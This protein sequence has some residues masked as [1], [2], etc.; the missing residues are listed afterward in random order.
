M[1]PSYVLF[2]IL[3]NFLLF[4]SFPLCILTDRTNCYPLSSSKSRQVF[5]AKQMGHFI[6]LLLF[7]YICSETL[8]LLIT[9]MILVF[10]AILPSQS[11]N[12]LFILLPFIWTFLLFCLDFSTQPLNWNVSLSHYIWEFGSGSLIWLILSNFCFSRICQ[13]L[14]DQ[15]VAHQAH[16]DVL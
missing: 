3:Y 11:I 8:H 15:L 12:V 1:L 5:D 10:W 14:L 9:L 2:L 4:F 13:S 7:Q 16:K 6:Q